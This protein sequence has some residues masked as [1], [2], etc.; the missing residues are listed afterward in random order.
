MT[1]QHTYGTRSLLVLLAFTLAA[2]ISMVLDPLNLGADKGGWIGLF[3]ADSEALVLG[4]ISTDLQRGVP[5]A[6]AM[7]RNKS[8]AHETAHTYRT[9][10]LDKPC[11]R[12]YT[13]NM[14][15]QRL[16]WTPAVMLANASGAPT[17]AIFVALKTLA[18][19]ATAV[20]M[21]VIVYGVARRWGSWASVATAALFLT[22]NQWV[23]VG[24]NLYW[25][26]VFWLAPP[27]WLV[28]KAVDQKGF[29]ARIAAGLGLA[30]IV[31]L[32]AGLE[33]APALLAMVCVLSLAL[34]GWKAAA[35]TALT[36]T[37][38]LG[39]AV[40]LHLAWAAHILGG[41]GN[42]WA[43]MA[44]RVMK[45]TVGHPDVT[46]PVILD[47][48]ESPV[49]IEVY[50]HLVLYPAHAHMAAA[51]VALPAL[52]VLALHH[53]VPGWSRTM[54]LLAAFWAAGLTWPIIAAPHTSIHGP[55]LSFL[56]LYATIPT[57][58]VATHMTQQRWRTQQTSGL[59]PTSTQQGT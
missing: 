31:K 18:A 3:Q 54:G 50:K 38:A 43:D 1:G 42:A 25:M 45:R 13:G 37:I 30:L 36:A 24:P 2:W 28:W 34:W 8:W 11:E 58:V 4:G 51:L 55:L 14:G 32:L 17:L 35:H 20:A 33:G 22:A 48:L 41:W 7:C 39:V 26:G 52:L 12:D 47:S 5:L 46:N 59:L 57:Y 56:T 6:S 16:V 9:D 49:W 44:V 29:T 40:G 10:F 21:A 27:A 23:M 15:I 19:L 53:K